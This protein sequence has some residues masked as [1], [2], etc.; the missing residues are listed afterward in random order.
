MGQGVGWIAKEETKGLWRLECQKITRMS[1]ENS[2]TNNAPF[3]D[4]VASSWDDR[5]P[6]RRSKVEVEER[7]ERGGGYKIDFF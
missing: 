3:A 7:E 2:P 4:A 6:C 5:H 1:K